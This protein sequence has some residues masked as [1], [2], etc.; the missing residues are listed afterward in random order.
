MATGK[1]KIFTPSSNIPGT[2]VVAKGRKKSPHQGTLNNHL[3]DG[4]SDGTMDKKEHHSLA[5]HEI[6]T[7]VMG[8]S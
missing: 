2:P 5:A 3:N 8:Q 4:D 1:A 7:K 6:P